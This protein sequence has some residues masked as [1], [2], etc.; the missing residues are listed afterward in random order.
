MAEM[1]LFR[2]VQEALS[3]T[4]KHSDTKKV[5]VAFRREDDA[6]LMEVRD[7]GKG[8]DP[9]SIPDRPDAGHHVGLLGMRERAALIGGVF[10]IESKPGKGTRITVSAPYGAAGS[11]GD[12]LAE[13]A[14]G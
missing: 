11:T 6:L 13:S 12:R 2:I 10:K 4:T 14:G 1:A 9:K 8:F 3:N 7:W 5:R